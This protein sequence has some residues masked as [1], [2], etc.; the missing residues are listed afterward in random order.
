MLS[1]NFHIL[2]SP[3]RF[4]RLSET[5]L[6]WLSVLAG[7]LIGSGLVWGLVIAPPDYLQGDAQRVMYVHVPAAWMAMLCYAVMAAL[8]ASLLVWKHQLAGIAACASAPIGL[9]F[10]AIALVTGS[11]WGKPTWGTYWVWDARLTSVLV[12]FFLYAGFIALAGSFDDRDRGM[13]AA[14]ILALIGIVNL[15]IIKFSVDWWNTLHQP[16]SVF[17][18]DGPTIHSSLLYPLIV[19]ALGFLALF[20]V[21]LLLRIRGELAMR[22]LETL[23]RLQAAETT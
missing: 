11:L 3:A 14:A 13:R 18:V 4:R 19:M 12:L 7:G 5:L 10:T 15:P 6:P 8:S 2:A 21:V 22:R 1:F 9:C 17:R 20:L 23:H 16:A